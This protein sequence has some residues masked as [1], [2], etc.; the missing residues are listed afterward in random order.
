MDL[1]AHADLPGGYEL[2]GCKRGELLCNRRGIELGISVESL[3]GC[4]VRGPFGNHQEL[5]A[6]LQDAD[7]AARTV[8]TR[9]I[10]NCMP[11]LI[12]SAIYIRGSGGCNG[13]RQQ[14]AG[15]EY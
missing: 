8:E 5:S 12:D 6:A 9:G 1:V 4:N 3:A 7:Y 2:G 10:A 14:E 11:D 13:R 15:D